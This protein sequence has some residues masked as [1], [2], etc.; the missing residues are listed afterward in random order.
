[1]CVPERAW[2]YAAERGS[3]LQQRLTGRVHV[4]IRGFFESING[5]LKTAFCFVRAPIG[6][7]GLLATGRKSRKSTTVSNSWRV[8]PSRRIRENKKYYTFA[9]NF[10]GILISARIYDMLRK[11]YKPVL[12][13]DLFYCGV[14]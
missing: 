11:S 13:E 7:I 9:W 5:G 12:L 6:E 14:S 3:L 1:M 8:G 2:I 4:H 10:I